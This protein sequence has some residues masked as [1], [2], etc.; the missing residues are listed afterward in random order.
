MQTGEF[1]EG[2]DAESVEVVEDAQELEEPHAEET[3][4][5]EE[6]AQ[7]ILEAAKAEADQI[8]ED[9]KCRRSICGSRQ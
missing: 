9:A 8:L 7:D 1:I 4:N 6:Q 2:L 5:E 3:V